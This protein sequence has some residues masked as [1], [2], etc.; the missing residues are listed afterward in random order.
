MASLQQL[1][2]GLWR[3]QVAIGDNRPSIRLGKMS[4]DRAKRLQKLIENLA[5]ARDTGEALDA[6]T[7]KDVARLS[8]KL[9][10]R[11]VK[12]GLIAGRAKRGLDD[13]IRQYIAERA[14]TKA[15]T[16]VNFELIRAN[17]VEFFG[18][19]KAIDTITEG[20]AEDFKRWLSVTKKLSANSCKRRS[21]I[22]KQFLAYAVKKGLLQSNP[23]AVLKGLQV[24][25][26]RER[27]V[28]IDRETID[29]VVDKA[30]DAEWRLMIA[31]SRWAGLR[32][33]S[34]HMALRWTDILWD[35]SKMVV[36]QPKLEHHEGHESRR[37]PIF[38]ELLPFLRTAF[39]LVQPE[40]EN[41]PS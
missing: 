12:A 7:R 39:V 40:M 37:V 38:V 20:D 35:E 18:S 2:G 32:C 36:R 4:E 33:P 16:R 10:G 19:D 8:P 28:F 30:P 27:F 11:F 13:F 6:D 26:N 29:K 15:R 24:T 23:F 21:A 9:A 22:V 34:E 3:V 31:L 5:L 41:Q 17:A 25:G 1:P 14:D